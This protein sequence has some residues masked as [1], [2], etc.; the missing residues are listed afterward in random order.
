MH[1]HVRVWVSAGEPATMVPHCATLWK[2]KEVRLKRQGHCW[3]G[4]VGKQAGLVVWTQY[5]RAAAA[6]IPAY[7]LPLTEHTTNYR[8]AASLLLD[9]SREATPAVVWQ[10][11]WHGLQHRSDALHAGRALLPC[12]PGGARTLVCDG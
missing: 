9:M 3:C 2:S 8:A 1:T 5:S 7:R 6:T 12:L 10:E 11:V 4:Y